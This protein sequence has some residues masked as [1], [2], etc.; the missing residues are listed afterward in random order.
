MR[1]S[2]AKAQSAK[3]AIIMASAG[4]HGE[5]QW[6]LKMAGGVSAKK[7]AANQCRSWKSAS[8]RRKR[9][10][11]ICQPKWRI[12]ISGGVMAWR[13]AEISK[14]SAWRRKWRS[15][16]GELKEIEASVMAVAES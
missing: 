15:G 10:G 5:N 1:R 3:S 14:A 16:A 9:R 12:E 7:M 6:Q 8:R 2:A 4:N 13:L 11:I